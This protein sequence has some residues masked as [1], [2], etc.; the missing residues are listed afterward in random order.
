MR[1]RMAVKVRTERALVNMSAKLSWVPTCT[2][3]TSAE[4]RKQRTHSN[5]ASI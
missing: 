5:L 3:S 2:T 4:S 1:L